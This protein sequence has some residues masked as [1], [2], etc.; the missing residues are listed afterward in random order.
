MDLLDSPELTLLRDSGARFVAEYADRADPERLWAHFRDL[1]WLGLDLPEQQG[2][3]GLGPAAA[4]VLMEVFGRAA[5]ASPYLTGSLF[6]AG[7][8]ARCPSAGRALE[9]LLHGRAR[10]AVQ[11]NLALPECDAAASGLAMA[12]GD[13]SLRLDGRALLLGWARPDAAIVLAQAV[14]DEPALLLLPVIDG[15]GAAFEPVAFADGGAGTRVELNDVAAAHGVVLA[16]GAPGRAIL[17]SAR[18]AALLGAAADNL[19]ATQALFD[20][21]LAHVKLRRQ[22]GRAIGSFQALQF[23]LADMWIKLDEARSL[24]MAAARAPT[25]DEAEAVRLTTAAWIQSLW[26][27]HMM[28]EEAVQMHG[29]IGMTEQCAVGRAFKHLL[30]NELIFGG[31]DVHLAAYDRLRQDRAQPR[32]RDAAA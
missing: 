6:A 13:A 30:V 8:L 15:P 9:A 27:G 19:G 12:E 28:A 7:I 4:A 24:V 32:A 31:E 2:G 16:R 3:S 14:R 21:T 26:S 11:A 20:A 1:G 29:A 18:L 17:D 23:R 10:V 5:L 25:D 22:F